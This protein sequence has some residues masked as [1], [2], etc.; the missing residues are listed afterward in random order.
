MK[1]DL[2]RKIIR[3]EI[4]RNLR[5][6]FTPDSPAGIITKDKVVEDYV[7]ID[8]SSNFED[9]RSILSITIK[10]H[11]SPEEKIK[12]RNI[13]PVKMY[14]HSY[15]EAVSHKNKILL[16]VQQLINELK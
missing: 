3:E 8:I 9:G 16:I 5:T 2:L 7:N 12:L 13:L 14:F 15:N 11:L 10:R 6:V 1:I 4:G